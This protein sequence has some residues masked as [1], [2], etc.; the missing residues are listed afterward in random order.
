MGGG[1]CNITRFP[2][3]KGRETCSLCLVEFQWE[4]SPCSWGAGDGLNH[5]HARGAPP[6]RL[7]PS[8]RVFPLIVYRKLTYTSKTMGL[9]MLKDLEVVL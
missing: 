9:P 5:R 2:K 3:I 4:E 7:S 1:C 8:P 6:R